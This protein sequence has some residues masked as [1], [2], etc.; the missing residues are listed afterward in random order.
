M[1]MLSQK[2]INLPLLET[3]FAQLPTPVKIHI[4][5]YKY[6]LHLEFM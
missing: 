5:E 2:F 4:Y 6:N 1:F 3:I